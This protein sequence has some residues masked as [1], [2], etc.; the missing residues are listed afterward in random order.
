MARWTKALALVLTI[1]AFAWFRPGLAVDPAGTA[2]AAWDALDSGGHVALMRHAT[3]PGVGD[4]PGLR[5]EDCETQR[6]LSDRGREQARTAGARFRERGVEVGGVFASQ[7]C[8]TLET[9][10]LLDLGEVQPLALLNSFYGVA[11]RRQPQTAD[12]RD[13]LARHRSPQ[14]LVLV[15]H[16]VNISALT[17]V[18]AMPGEIV[19]V[20]PDPSGNVDLVGRIPPD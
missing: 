10:R 17:N 4:P 9:A 15:T 3:A 14:A 2:T 1:A 5:L 7:W 18:Y 16:Q 19:V 6:N 13:W 12:L 8:R 20:R 11:E